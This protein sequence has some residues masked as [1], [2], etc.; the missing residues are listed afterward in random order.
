MLQSDSRAAAVPW[1]VWCAALAVTSAII[2]G[3]WDIS[4]HRSIGRDTFWTPAHV[5]IY[6]C[7]VLAGVTAGVTILGTTF[8][9]ESRL[10]PA[11]V[12]VFGF[13]G[14]LGSF[15]CAWGGIAM[16]TSAPFDDWWHGAYG[17]DV[18][19]LSPPHTVLMAG[20]GAI[21]MGTVALV[22]SEMNR[23]EGRR[24]ARL[25]AV[26][27]Y[28][29]GLLT[30]AQLL[31][32]MEFTDASLMHSGIFYRVIATALPIFFAC[33]ARA[34]GVPFATTIVAA[35]YTVFMLGFLWILP[36]FPAEPK[37]GPVYHRVTHF[38][39]PAF[40]LLLVVPAAALDLAW[41]WAGE[42][43]RWALAAIGGVVFV[44]ALIAVQWPFSTFLM[45]EGARNWF[46][47]AHYFDFMTPPEAQTYTFWAYERTRGELFLNLSLA[48]AIAIVTMRIGIA[49]GDGLRRVKR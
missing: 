33:I 23:A 48:F 30:V 13:R 12:R 46:F 39:P 4:W 49:L 28:V 36:L 11:S 3:H 31:V 24:R 25:E 5:A 18:A 9:T 38:V 29:G 41:R 32:V 17:L 1:Y 37:L 6:I 35:I 27:L 21:E 19:I 44:G 45:T 7:G 8:S 20:I 26:A 10:R 42:R 40:P 22:F 2:G 47:G 14:P 15:L 43:S 34:S 16:L